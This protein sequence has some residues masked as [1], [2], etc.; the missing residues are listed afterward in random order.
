M[1]N[2][3]TH[4]YGHKWKMGGSEGRERESEGRERE[5]EGR[6]RERVAF[7]SFSFLRTEQY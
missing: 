5:S 2:N 4:L 1:E 3:Y 7:F 6:E